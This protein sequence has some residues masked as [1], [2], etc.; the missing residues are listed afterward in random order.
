LASRRLLASRQPDPRRPCPPRA[1]RRR[2]QQLAAPRRTAA[3][4]TSTGPS[5][6]TGD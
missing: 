1:A 3:C 4:R 2:H 6:S 5:A